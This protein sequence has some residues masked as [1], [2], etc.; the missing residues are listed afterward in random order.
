M[1]VGTD[2]PQFRMEVYRCGAE[3]VLAGRSGWL[4]GENAPLHLPFQDWGEPGVG[5]RG[6]PLAPWPAHD[7]PVPEDWPS[8]VYVTVF[9]EGDGHG[10]DRTHPDPSTPDGR[11][12]RALFVVRPAPSA[13]PAP[14]L[15]KI[16]LLTYHAYNL[17][18][19]QAY[20]PAT[21]RGHW[22][23]YNLPRPS[24]LPVEVPSGVGLHRPDGGTGATPYD[25]ANFDP[26]DPTPRQTFAQLPRR[27][28]E[29][30]LRALP[31]LAGHRRLVGL[32]DEVR[33]QRQRVQVGLLQ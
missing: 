8:G 30:P 19:G 15:Y 21:A 28:L 27:L 4:P 22:C 5:L 20:D 9:V 26:F 7:F 13:R 2:A 17:I 3:V 16:P 12:A 23:L 31:S 1:H 29:P 32:A 14:I 24:E 11:E 6:E 25:I 10:R 18:D 33:R